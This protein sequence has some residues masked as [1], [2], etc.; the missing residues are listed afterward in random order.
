MGC[1]S[2]LAAQAWRAWDPGWDPQRISKGEARLLLSGEGLDRA[3][4]SLAEWGGETQT[5]VGEVLGPGL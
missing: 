3:P 5:A 1:G 4:G 2:T